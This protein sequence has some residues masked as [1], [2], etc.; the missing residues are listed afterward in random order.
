ML[1]ENCESSPRESLCIARERMSRAQKS[2]C[3]QYKP[4]LLLIHKLKNV[5]LCMRLSI[6]SC[7]ESCIR[8]IDQGTFYEK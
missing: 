7:I 4:V 1:Y 8:M 3:K 2:L 6:S 5:C